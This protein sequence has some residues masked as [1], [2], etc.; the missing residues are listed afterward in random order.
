M[1]IS[2][3]LREVYK[4]LTKLLQLILCIPVTTVSSERNNSALKRIKTFLRNTMNHDRL[5]NL[6]TLAIEKNILD[7]LIIDPTF[8]DRVIDLFSNTK[9]RNIDLKYKVL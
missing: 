8:I 5:T 2:A 4:E 3:D 6:G 9:N 7:E 1:H